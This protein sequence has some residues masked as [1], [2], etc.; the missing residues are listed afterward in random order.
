M[1]ERAEEKGV[2][3]K[4]P[5]KINLM[6]EVVGQRDDGFHDIVTRICPLS[7]AD[8]LTLVG[9]NE[10]GAVLE[11]EASDTE[12]PLGEENL[13]LQ[14]VRAFERRF[15][16]DVNVRLTLTKRIP[17]SAGLGG[18]SSDAASTLVGLNR[19]HE[20]PF[21]QAELAEIGAEVGS[22]VPFFV[23]QSVCDCRGRGEIVE[24]IDF[25]WE[26]PIVLVKP[27][28]GIAAGWAYERWA[29]SKELP[30]V[31]YAPQIC[32]WGEMR[33]DL[34]RPVFEKYLLLAEIKRWLM[35]Q[36]EAQAVLMSGSGATV[37]A[38]LSGEHRG[39]ALVKKAVARY[40]PD[41]WTFSGRTISSVSTH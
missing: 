10:G 13:V 34:E 29:E 6:L 16:R 18:G 32:Y 14:A 8:D 1:K 33:N 30:G 20:N 4:A 23:Y 25:H 24:A 21:G 41:T 37:F 5:A 35:A 2:R 26:L 12:V 27:N 9:E 38:V 7:L 28:F 40:G 11:V 19:L 31:C 36:A 22:D 39:E 15:G 17:S 3:L